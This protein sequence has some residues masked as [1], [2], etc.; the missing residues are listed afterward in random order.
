MKESR[1]ISR[2]KRTIEVMV[3]MHCRDTHNPDDGLCGDCEELL[4]Y[5]V[6]RI[7]KC[8]FK[9]KKPQC[10]KCPVHC[11][12]PVLRGKVKEAM[13]YSGPRMLKRHPVLAVLHIIDGFLYKP[14]LKKAGNK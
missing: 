7:D 13:R 8:P 4:D 2:E 9:D 3:R 11:Y 14:E 12:K 5:A 6:K 1:R 10:N